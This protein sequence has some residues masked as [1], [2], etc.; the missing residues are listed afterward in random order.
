MPSES[1]SPETRRESVYTTLRLANTWPKLKG[2]KVIYPRKMNRSAI[3]A[4]ASQKL[5]YASDRWKASIK[6]TSSTSKNS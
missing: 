3:F 1:Q 2:Y 4:A 5:N 6:M